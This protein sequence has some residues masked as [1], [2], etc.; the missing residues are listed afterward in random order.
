MKM[1]LQAWQVLVV[2]LV[3][4]FNREQQ[5]VIEYLVAL[6]KVLLED[7]DGKR[8]LLNDVQRRRLAVKSK[9]LSRKQIFD[10]GIPFHPDTLLRWHRTLVAKKW[11]Y[12][13]RRKKTAGRQDGRTAGRLACSPK[14]VPCDMRVY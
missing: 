2:I 9:V 3:S 13:D 10:L 4:L 11:D 7:R 14:V 1:H 8:L 12:T 6:I 5:Q